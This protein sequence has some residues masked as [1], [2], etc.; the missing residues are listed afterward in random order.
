MVDRSD[1][2]LGIDIGG[3]GIKV[4]PVDTSNGK[5]LEKAR[6]MATPRPAHPE[7]MLPEIFRLIESFNWKNRIGVGFPGVIK[8]GKVHTAANLEQDWLGV[9][10]QSEIQK[11]L[12]Q[13]TTVINDADAAALAEMKFGAGQPNNRPNGGVV[14]MITLGTG[15]GSALF[16]NGHLVPNT[17]FG[18][19][20]MK[21][22]DAEKWAATVIREKE[23]LSWAEWGER[24]NYFLQTMEMLLSPDLIIIGGGISESPEKFFPYLHIKT[25]IVTANL[26]NDA[27]IVGAALN[28]ALMS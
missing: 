4:A 20:E 15:I 22:K 28:A 17:E 11:K 24:V 6:K 1:E 27:G 25:R 3:T 19:M 8:N 16:V 12:G 18:H 14:L 5:L 10:L 7:S 13:Q 23:N 21:G 2:V 26:T 9:Q